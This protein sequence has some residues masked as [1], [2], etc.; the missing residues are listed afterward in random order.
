MI[1]VMGIAVV[2]VVLSAIFRKEREFS[3]IH[4]QQAMRNSLMRI[5]QKN[6]RYGL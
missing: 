4:R 2:I 3:G 6:Q 1:E 5:Q